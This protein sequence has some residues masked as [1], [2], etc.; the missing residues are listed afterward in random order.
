[1][2]KQKLQQDQIAALKNQE[3]EKLNV[4]RYILSLIKNKEIDKKQDLTDDE[5][6][7]ILKKFAKELNESIEAF[8]KGG[9]EELASEYQRQLLIVEKYLPQPLSQEE[10]KKEIEKIIKENQSL[11]EKNPKAIIPLVMKKLKVF[12]DG[13]TIMNLLSFYLK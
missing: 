13:Q 6:I 11:F 7:L 2:L 3:K 10:L 1:M 12:A 9:R 4:L 5:I 8:K